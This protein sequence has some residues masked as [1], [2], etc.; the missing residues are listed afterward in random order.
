H[1]IYYLNLTTRNVLLL[2]GLPGES[3]YKDGPGRGARFKRPSSI[4]LSSDGRVLTVADEDNS[5][6]RLIEI[7]RDANGDPA[8]N[9]TTLGV[10]SSAQG[11]VMKELWTLDQ[12]DDGILFDHPQSV[13]VD[14][15]GNIYVVDRTG[16]QVV[17]RAPGQ[18][19]QVLPLAQPE[20]SF[21]Q[22]V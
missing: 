6:V 14:G 17:T 4:A 1:A 5:R 21:N 2:A 15:A 7:T 3:G 9:V 11:V 18:M 19:P 22:A 8:G 12:Q 20:V 16:V 10:A 13:G